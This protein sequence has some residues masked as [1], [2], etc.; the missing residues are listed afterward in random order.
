MREVESEFNSVSI[1]VFSGELARYPSFAICLEHLNVP[2]NSQLLWATGLEFVRNQNVMVKEASGE[3]IFILGDDHTFH[4]SLLMNLLKHNVDIVV[5]LVSM[6]QPPFEP[7]IIREPIGEGRRYKWSEIN[8]KGLMKLP[9]GS[10]VGSAG[11]LIKKEVFKALPYPYFECGKVFTDV[12]SEDVSF[13]DKLARYG[14][15]VH[16]DTSSVMGHITPS[17]IIPEQDPSGK[18]GTTLS[19][20]TSPFRWWMRL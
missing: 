7:V 11:M 3:Y 13:A 8:S 17:T 19:I 20:G 1:C 15:Q 14:Y 18:W 9:I 2:R 4:P 16:V 6:R 12:I 10:T 5:P